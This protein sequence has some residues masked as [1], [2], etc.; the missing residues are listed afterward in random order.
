MV[1]RRSVI[2]P[3]ISHRKNDGKLGRNWLKG[4]PSNAMHAVLC[5]AGHNTRLIINK[6]DLARL[7]PRLIEKWNCSGPTSAFPA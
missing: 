2:K 6:L 7:W 3:T 5:A 1:K 4:T